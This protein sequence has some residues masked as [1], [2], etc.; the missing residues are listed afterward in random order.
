MEGVLIEP[1][2]AADLPAAAA[3]A[4]VTIPAA[5]AA[6]GAGQWADMIREEVAYKQALMAAA[7][8]P[9]AG[10]QFLVAKIDGEVVGVISGSP[11][12]P[13]IRRCTQEQLAAVPELGSLFIRP[14]WQGRGIGSCLISSMVILL[15]ERG[16]THFCLDSGYRLAQQR[17]L[18]KFGKPYQIVANYWGEGFDH[19]IWLCPF[20]DFLPPQAGKR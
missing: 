13:D 9:G 3:V 11:C 18:R 15:A 17:W 19:M 8:Q 20:A 2:S 4:A 1:L 5:F 12:G 7:L 16:E 6:A 10:V 14:E